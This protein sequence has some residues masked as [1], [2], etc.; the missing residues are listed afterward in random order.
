MGGGQNLWGAMMWWAKA[1]FTLKTAKWHPFVP[2][3]FPHII[4]N[5]QIHG[6][7]HQPVDGVVNYNRLTAC[8]GEMEPFKRAFMDISQSS[9]EA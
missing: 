2:F 3:T 1:M 4:Q 9:K 6:Q 8:Q 5:N 7:T